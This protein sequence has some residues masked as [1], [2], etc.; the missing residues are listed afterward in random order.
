MM[1]KRTV[2]IWFRN[3]LR[4]QDNEMLSRANER[5]EALVPVYCFDPRYYK[6]TK[7]GIRKTGINRAR[8]INESVQKLQDYFKSKKGNLIIKYG[9]P[10]DIIPNLVGQYQINEVYHHREVAQEETDISSSVEDALWR[11][12]I[13]LRHFI[14]HT[15]HHKEDFPFP[16]KDIPDSFSIFRKQAERESFIRECFPNVES[17]SFPELEE[18]VLPTMEELGFD[19]EEIEQP[20]SSLFNGGEEEGQK[21]LALY[22]KKGLTDASVILSPWLSLGCLSMHSVYFSLVESSL[23]KRMKESI[24]QGLLWKDYY[25]FMFKKYGN[26]FFQEKG[27][28]GNDPI[29]GKDHHTSFEIWKNAGTPNAK[30]NTIMTQLNKTGYIDFD[31]REEAASYLV[32]HLQVNWL[33]G[34]AYFEE[35]LIDYNPSSNYGNWAHIAGVGSS[36]EHNLSAFEGML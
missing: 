23:P 31:S 32:H 2:L 3:D 20:K 35:K 1:N 19:P 28:T 5:G 13:N 18:S 29:V 7:F 4:I 16:V 17:F 33:L 24:L 26:L 14:G 36:K 12:K 22:I 27:Y 9:H 6:K 25:R 21:Q 10:E 34:A 30:I 11:M 8:F 15:L